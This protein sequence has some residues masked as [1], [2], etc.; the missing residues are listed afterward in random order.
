MV[1]P[2]VADGGRWLRGGV[3]SGTVDRRHRSDGGAATMQ[4][5]ELIIVRPAT[6]TPDVV[7]L[8]WSHPERD[9]LEL[10]GPEFFFQNPEL[11]AQ[12]PKC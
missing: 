10:H 9:M 2:Q 1:A 11:L 5:S 6:L 3:K 4:M 7:A 12:A 8:M